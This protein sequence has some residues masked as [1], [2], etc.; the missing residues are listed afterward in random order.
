MSS[1]EFRI[2]E[3]FVEIEWGHCDPAGI[4]FYPRYFEMFDASTAHL[5]A[6]ATGLSKFDLLRKHSAAGFPMVNTGAEFLRPAKYGDRVRIDSTVTRLGTSSFDIRHRLFN[7]EELA[8]DAFE[9]RVWVQHT[10]E[11]KIRAAP[12]PPELVSALRSEPVS[13]RN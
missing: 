2:F 1:T 6:T 9:K 11:G 7:G 12:L 13:T 8:I 10:D 4:V 3:R 5:I